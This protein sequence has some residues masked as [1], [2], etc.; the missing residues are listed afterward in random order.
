[1][2]NRTKFRASLLVLILG[3]SFAACVSNVEEQLDEPTTEDPAV[4]TM[5]SFNSVVKPIIDGR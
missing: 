2:N 1:M 4:V 3:I 5:V